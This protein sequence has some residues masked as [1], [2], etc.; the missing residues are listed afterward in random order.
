[1][2]HLGR[3]ES[4]CLCNISIYAGS[5]SSLSGKAIWN[6]LIS[7]RNLEKQYVEVFMEN[8]IYFQVLKFI[9]AISL[10]FGSCKPKNFKTVS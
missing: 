5:T 6:S 9:F 3:F 10:F 7:K 8:K 1:M 4:L 2:A